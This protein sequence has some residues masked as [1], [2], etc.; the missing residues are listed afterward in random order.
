MRRITTPF[1]V[2]VALLLAA[3]AFARDSRKELSV[4]L[5]FAPQEGVKANSPDLTP[6]VLER[7]IAFNVEDARGGDATAIGQATNDDDE[8][9][10]VRASSDVIAYLTDTVR[11]VASDWGV[12]TADKPDRVL[13]LKVARFFV[14]ESNKALGSVYAAEVK[15]TYTLADASGKKLIEGAASGSAHRYGRA[16]SADNCN[17]VLSDSLKEAFA[18]VIS[19]PRLQEAWA[20]GKASGG[21]TA[22]GGSPA[23]E[24]VEERLRKLDDLLKKGL[25]TKEEYNKKRAEILKDI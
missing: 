16:R 3:S 1:F 12:K 2:I 17:E 6:S 21:S 22:G 5:K 19:D 15:F 13:T 9:F 11:Q 8:S 18:N 24:S 10:P 20:S 7:T 25:I 14:D 23:A 4:N